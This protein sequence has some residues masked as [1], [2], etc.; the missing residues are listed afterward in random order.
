MVILKK[1]T[2]NGEKK[3]KLKAA[4]WSKGEERS[5]L[6]KLS[7]ITTLENKKFMHQENEETY[8]NILV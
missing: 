6:Y 4:F 5:K 3:R 7:C 1:V 2:T 8:G